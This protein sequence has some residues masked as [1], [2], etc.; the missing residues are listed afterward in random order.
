MLRAAAA[1]G[2][3]RRRPA[4]AEARARPARRA[5]RR[6]RPRTTRSAPRSLTRGSSV[7]ASSAAVSASGTAKRVQPATR[8]R[9]TTLW[10][11]ACQ[12]TTGLYTTG[13]RRLQRPRRRRLT[14]AARHSILA[15]AS[16]RSSRGAHD[17]LNILGTGR[18]TPWSVCW[19][20]S[21]P[22]SIAGRARRR[23]AEGRLARH[24]RR[25]HV[26]PLL[27][28]S[29]RSTP[30][31]FNTLKV[32]WEWRG[33]VPP[34]VEIGDINARGAA[35]LRRRHADHDVGPAAHGRV[36][37]SGHRQDAVD[38]SRSRRR[39]ATSTR[40]ASNH[41]KGVAY[42]RINGRGVVF[43][44][45]PG[46]LPARARRQDRP[47]ARGLGRR[48]AGRRLPEDRL[49]R[50]A[51]GPD[52]RLGAVASDAKQPY[53]PAKGL[54]LELGYITTSSPPI[55]VNDVLVVGNSA[56]QGYNQTRIENVPGDILAYDAQDRQV[57]VEVPRHSAAGR[58]RP[59]D[60]GERRVAVDRRR[61]VVGA[62]VGRP[63]SAA[64][65]TSRPTARRS[66][67][68]AASVRATTCS[69]P[70]SSRST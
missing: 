12:L 35:D 70:A 1:P 69:A 31:N 37:R 30:S 24:H 54:P 13:R 57:H 36:A 28:R 68:T 5:G 29:I 55:V 34:G 4:R 22:W 67:T 2:R 39:R 65:S 42:A 63:G 66:T 58:V 6:R 56:E 33:E 17:R 18:R 19:P 3:S 27:A 20:S 48:G 64:S 49:G 25:R 23:P 50:P 53:D 10:R 38:A 21:S 61:V 60:V 16:S 14:S 62:D 32:A 51:E 43:V 59:R 45:T 11:S 26:D 7:S 40:C 46:L 47:A 44:T 9:S 52:R 8:C 41:G 15:P